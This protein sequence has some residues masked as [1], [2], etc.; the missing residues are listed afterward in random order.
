M[1]QISECYD[2]LRELVLKE[3]LNS[4]LPEDIKTYLAEK[5]PENLKK[6]AE[7]ADHYSLIHTHDRKAPQRFNYSNSS[8]VQNNKT[9][10]STNS[11]VKPNN[12]NKGQSDSKNEKQNNQVVKQKL[13]CYHCRKLGHVI[14][15]CWE[16]KGSPKSDGKN[17]AGF[18]S[19]WRKQE[20]HTYYRN[21]NVIADRFGNKNDKCNESSDSGIVNCSL[22]AEF[23]PFVLRALC[24]KRQIVKVPKL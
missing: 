19:Q 12:T 7:L 4:C 20:G 6:S 22:P 2:N 8:A 9:G 15:D 24:L 13:K 10:V 1:G 23:T 16:L 21:H 11:N 3:Q 17:P 14:S 5:A 18:V